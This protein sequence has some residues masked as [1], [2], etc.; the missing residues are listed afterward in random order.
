MIV[1]KK[2]DC[3]RFQ[4]EDIDRALHFYKESLGMELVWRIGSEEAGLRMGDSEL[5][6]VRDELEHPEI[7]LMVDSV[8]ESIEKF[9]TSGGRVLIEPFE[10]KIGY[11]S[12]LEDPWKNRFVVLDRSKGLLKV[13]KKKNVIQDE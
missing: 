5:V 12:V 6:L 10:I 11:C 3:V 13:D 1:F 4:V 8:Q 9:R 7:D 2:I